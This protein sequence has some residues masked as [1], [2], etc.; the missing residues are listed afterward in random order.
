MKEVWKEIKFAPTRYMV[1]N[2]GRV[3]NIETGKVLRTTIKAN[4]YK[5]VMLCFNGMRKDFSVHRL[6]AE[7]FLENP[8]GC[9]YVNHKDEC[10]TNN[11]VN[12]LEWCTASYNA[13]YGMGAKARNS[14][15]QQIDPKNGKIIRTWDSMKN[16]AGTL[17]INYQNISR[18]CRGMRKTAGGYHWEYIGIHRTCGDKK[19][20]KIQN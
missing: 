12:N 17:G 20:D 2:L 7:T 13:N 15:V 11:N 10:K 3:K 19:H 5:G 6:V 14:K 1:S 16:A 8:N 4:G 18:V 9:K